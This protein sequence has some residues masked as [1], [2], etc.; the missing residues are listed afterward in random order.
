MHMSFSVSKHT[1]KYIFKNCF[2]YSLK[3]VHVSDVA[4]TEF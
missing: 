1:V 4:V 2:E 3:A